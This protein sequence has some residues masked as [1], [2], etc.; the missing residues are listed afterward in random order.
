MTK[1]LQEGVKQTTRPTKNITTLRR[2]LKSHNN[3]HWPARLHSINDLDHLRDIAQ[4][5]SDW[6]HL[7]TAEGRSANGKRFASARAMQRPSDQPR[8]RPSNN[9]NNDD[10]DDNGDA[11]GDDDDDDN[12]DD[13]D[14][15]NNNDNNNINSNC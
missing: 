9:N 10:N 14:D 8:Q 6:K 4:N 1:L 7:T 15:E 11:D 3:D 13:G 2:D 12:D 5:R